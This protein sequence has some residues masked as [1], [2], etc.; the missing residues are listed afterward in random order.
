[1][2]VEGEILND[3][4]RFIGVL[5]AEFAT[6]SV[7]NLALK[8]KGYMI[9]KKLDLELTIDAIMRKFF[10]YHIVPY[11]EID[12]IPVALVSRLGVVSKSTDRI[13]V[14]HGGSREWVTKQITQ[15]KDRLQE[16]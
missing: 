11:R 5:I 12:G 9:I 4:P 15:R 2:A 14:S 1:M 3:F 6:D 7:V 16:S 10:E 13:L 8:M